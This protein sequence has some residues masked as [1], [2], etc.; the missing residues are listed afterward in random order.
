MGGAVLM[1]ISRQ[2]LLIACSDVAQLLLPRATSRKQEN[3]SAALGQ[4]SRLI[5]QS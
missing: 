5:R 4:W 2:M 3:R 1:V